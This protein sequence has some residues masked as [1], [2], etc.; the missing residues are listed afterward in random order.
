[1][2]MG[3]ENQNDNPK[4]LVIFFLIDTSGSMKGKKMG[5]LNNVMEELI[6]E[7]KRLKEKENTVIKAAVLTF[8]TSARWMYAAPVSV[9]DFDWARLRADGIT[10]MDAAFTELEVKLR[11]KRFVGSPEEYYAPVFFLMTDGY[12]S[13]NYKKGLKLLYANPWFKCGVRVALGIGPETDDK[14]LAEFTGSEETV[15]HAYSGAQL[16]QMIK[17]VTVTAALLSTTQGTIIE[18][19][20]VTQESL[21]RQQ[22][23]FDKIKSISDAQTV[24]EPIPFSTGW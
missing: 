1:M 11:D 9:D 23:L 19:E 24:A 17:G 8:S 14:A 4:E 16:S 22:L 12:P 7:I 21:K 10:S 3:I 13:D 2:K 20:P 18:D 6:P 5:E 15:V